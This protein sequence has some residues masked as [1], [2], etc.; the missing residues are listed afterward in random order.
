[1][2]TAPLFTFDGARGVTIANNDYDDGFNRRID[3]RNMDPVEITADGEGLALNADRQTSGP[4]EITYASSDESVARVSADGLVM[5]VGSGKA[6]IR[7]H[8]TVGGREAVSD[9]VRIKVTGEADDG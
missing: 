6:L 2:D 1:M 3:T 8:V 7:A 4:V 5:A 9:P